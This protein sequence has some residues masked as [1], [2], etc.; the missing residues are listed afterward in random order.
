MSEILVEN[1][2]QDGIECGIKVSYWE[3]LDRIISSTPQ[4]TKKKTHTTNVKSENEEENNG[5][6]LSDEPQLLT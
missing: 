3:R 1:G 5:K 4:G 6:I 2:V